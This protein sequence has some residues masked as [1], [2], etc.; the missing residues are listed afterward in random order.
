MVV[1]H[2]VLR[3]VR[4]MAFLVAALVPSLGLADWESDYPQHRKAFERG[5][6][7]AVK[8]ILEKDRREPEVGRLYRLD[9]LDTGSALMT[10]LMYAVDSGNIELVKYLRSLG[11]LDTCRKMSRC[12][13][14]HFAAAHGHLHLIKYFISQGFD[15]YKDGGTGALHAAAVG[16]HFETLKFLCEKGIDNNVKDYYGKTTLDH[17]RAKTGVRSRDPRRDARL[18]KDIPKIVEYLTNRDCT[19]NLPSKR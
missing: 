2:Q 6:L 10:A 7:K 9:N 3:A 1:T 14:I 18:R 15:V 17:V 19:K 4:L 8:R 16:G 12:G 5:N 13:V 11:W